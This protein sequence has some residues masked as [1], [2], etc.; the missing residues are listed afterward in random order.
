MSTPVVPTPPAESAPSP[1]ASRFWRLME[2][3][4]GIIPVP[5]YFLL[6]AVVSYLAA[7]GK[8]TIDISSTIAVVALGAY[9]LAEL[10]DRIPFIKRIGGAAILC[11][12]LPSFLIHYHLIPA[13][14]AKP[15]NE[16]TGIVALLY[17]YIACIIVGSIMGM[18][19]SSLIRCFLKIVIP[20]GLGTVF[21]VAAGMLVGWAFGQ[22]PRHVFFYVII[23]ILSGG[24]GEGAIPLSIGYAD[25]LH[26]TP[27]AAYAMVLPPVI[28]GSLIAMILTGFLNVIGRRFPHLTGNGRL[29]RNMREEFPEH[30]A[31]VS[32]PSLDLRSIGAAIIFA[33]TLYIIG[34]AG[35]ELCGLPAPIGMLVAAVLL[36]L[37]RVLPAKFQQDSHLVYRFTAVVVTYPMVFINSLGITPWDKLVAAFTV[38]NFAIMFTTVATMMGTGFV[39]ARWINM[40]PVELAIVNACRC[41]RGG[42]GTVTILETGKRMEL[43]PFG[44]VAVRIGG[45]ITVTAAIIA[46]ARFH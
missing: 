13:S 23:P 18:D 44:Q 14:I 10:G 46:L 3:K 35:K 2:L 17:L 5:I 29:E 21:A 41:A 16:F 34:V 22:D 9:A 8:L 27:A 39:V 24:I 20:T 28:V 12:V 11:A 1:W 25:V 36:K 37:F 19:R 6:L 26:T 42:S 43:M 4:I 33:V 40:Y 38:A 32:N 15:L 31:Q 45:A 30:G 7:T